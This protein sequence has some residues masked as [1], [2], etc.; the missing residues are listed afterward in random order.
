MK[1]TRKQIQLEKRSASLRAEAYKLVKD[2]IIQVC[3]RDGLTFQSNC[4]WGDKF[5]VR[6]EN[7]KF[8]EQ[9]TESPE[10]SE[11]FW[12]CY[13]EL[14]IFVGGMYKNGKWVGD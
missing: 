10:I 8:L 3:K 14:D 1:K 9:R 13:R 7:K 5:E 12:W 4:L 6:D 2:K 11:I